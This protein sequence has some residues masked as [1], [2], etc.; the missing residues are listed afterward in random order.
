MLKRLCYILPLS[1]LLLSC[2]PDT[3]CRTANNIGVQ[4]V[5]AI[6]SLQGDTLPVRVS[7]IDSI[8]VRGIG[9]DSLL[10]DN[11]KRLS[12]IFL[13]L[14]T[15]NNLTAYA[16]QAYDATDTLYIYH[17]NNVNFISLACG[18]FVFHTITNVDATHRLIDSLTILNATIENYKQDNL[19]L[20]LPTYRL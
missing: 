20:Y 19:R 14:R 15:D 7:Q 13:P 8:S 11:Q 17:D 6:D 3:E 1:L 9:N 16:I 5:F 12:S 10:Y 4:I 18:C 2:E